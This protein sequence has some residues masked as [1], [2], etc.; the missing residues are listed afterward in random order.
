MIRDNI[1]FAHRNVVHLSIVYELGVRSIDLK[2]DFTP[3]N[4]LFEA[5]NLTKNVHPDKYRYGGEG[6]EFDACSQFSLSNGDGVKM[7][8]FLEL[9]IV[10]PRMQ[11]IEK[12]IS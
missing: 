12:K 4:C 3:G 1:S 6:I 5:M 9:I 8:L 11:I 7:L 2:L 10:L